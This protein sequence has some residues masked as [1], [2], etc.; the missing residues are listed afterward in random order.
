MKTAIITSS[1]SI[2]HLTGNGH[3]EKPDRVTVVIE[4]LKQNKNLIWE[5]SVKFD[6]KYLN[7][8]HSKNY[9]LDVKKL[10]LNIKL[11]I[12]FQEKLFFQFL[13]IQLL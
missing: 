13:M 4:K 11:I 5:N 6:E 1:T 3:P 12:V 2:N 7:I 10:N 9:V 8:T